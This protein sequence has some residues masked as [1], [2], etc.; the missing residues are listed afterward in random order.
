[1]PSV[2]H[3]IANLGLWILERPE[4]NVA[5]L[6]FHAGDAERNAEIGTHEGQA[7]R[8][9]IHFVHH[10]RTETGIPANPGKEVMKTGSDTAQN[11]NERLIRQGA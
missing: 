10:F 7:C 5:G 9:A 11:E 1:M 6:A 2:N 8:G 4:D 3:P